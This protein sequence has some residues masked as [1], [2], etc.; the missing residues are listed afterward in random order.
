[1]QESKA[2]PVKLLKCSVFCR[3]LAPEDEDATPEEIA[4]EIL[5]FYP[6][7]TSLTAQL[8]FINTCEGF[9]DFS[10]TF[11]SKNPIETIHLGQSRIIVHEV[12]P[13]TYFV[14]EVSAEVREEN[15]LESSHKRRMGNAFGRRNKMVYA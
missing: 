7:N 6:S 5:Y 12:E 4:E 13:E 14:L 15:N 11:D 1:M 8:H 3:K 10:R 9:I 2:A